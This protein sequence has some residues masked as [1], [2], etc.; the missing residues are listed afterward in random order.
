MLLTD[1]SSREDVRSVVVNFYSKIKENELLGPIFKQHITDWDTHFELLT[2]FWE[3]NLFLVSKYKGNP[4]MVHNKVDESQHE[5][6]DQRYFVEW[7]KIWNTTID[8]LFKGDHATIMKNRARNMSSHLWIQMV[9][10][11]A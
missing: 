6:I 1:L 4:I 7:L 10:N 11:R 3:S 5:N 2:D 8:S 9:K